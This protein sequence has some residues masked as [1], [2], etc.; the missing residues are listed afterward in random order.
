MM[1][2]PL[3]P[4]SKKGVLVNFTESLCGATLFAT[5]FFGSMAAS[6]LR[7]EEKP[8]KCP[9]DE[10]NSFLGKPV[11]DVQ[12]KLT[13]G[14]GEAEIDGK[15]VR[16]DRY[17]SFQVAQDGSI[18]LLWSESEKE[19]IYVKRSENGGKTWSSPIAVGE[20]IE[21]DDRYARVPGHFGKTIL[22]SSMIDETTG[23][24]LVFTSAFKPAQVLHR[25]RDHG[26]TWVTE[27]ITIKKDKNGWLPCFN[28]A[29]VPAATLKH[30]PKKGRLLMPTR[31][32]VQGLNY[33]PKKG[34]R[35][36]DKHYSNAAYSDDHGKTWTPSEPFPIE[37][38]GES[39][40]LELSDGRFYHNSRT[41]IRGGNRRIAWSTD[42]GETWEGEH[43]DKYLPDGPPDVYGCKG[44][45]VRLPIADRDVL[46][47]S[48][49][50]DKHTRHRQPI[51][52]RASFD[53][54]K[55][56]PLAR[57]LPDHE[58]AGYTWLGAGRP[59]TP[60]EGMIYLLSQTREF[61]RFNLA[62][63]LEKNELVEPTPRP[64]EN[65]KK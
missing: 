35:V 34:P 49:P 52:V 26:K 25:S 7:A 45:L 31:V 28:A 42:G 61:V 50:R 13:P 30:G 51:T 15:K 47:Y 23:D 22:G 41:H 20:L 64:S 48:S 3:N 54:A 40:L 29:C 32:F 57:T 43:E 55:T 11:F 58:I 44:G 46:I 19:L 5:A 1:L 12:E 53:G 37:G 33:D 27:E 9:L 4:T 56:W 36:F 38:T 39:G 60:S 63:M 18:L 16:L 10:D 21:I 65:A 17:V 2:N 62:W 14:S 24:V 8:Y 59:G 6:P